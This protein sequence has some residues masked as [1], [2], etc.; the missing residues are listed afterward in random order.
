MLHSDTMPVTLTIKQLHAKTGDLVRQA[1]ASRTPITITDRGVPIAVLTSPAALKAPRR[2][3]TLLPEYI[4]L[5]DKTPSS[6]VMDDLDAVRG[7]R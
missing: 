3:R 6:D 2:K 1:G 5:M 7:E 4:T